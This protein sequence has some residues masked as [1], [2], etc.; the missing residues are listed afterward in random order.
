LSRKYGLTIDNLRS[1]DVVTANGEIVTASEDENADLF[2]GIRGGGGNFGV[3]TSFEFDLH[4]VGTEVLSGLIVHPYADARE[5]LTYYREFSSD[6][7]GD[8]NVWTVLRKAPPMPFL[9]EDVHG[10]E[11]LILAAFWSGDLKQGE[12][13]LRPLREHGNPIADVISPHA[14]T[15]WQTAFDPLL[16]P[17]SRNYWKSHNFTELSDGLLD[18]AVEYL[19]KLPS[20][21]TEIFFGQLGGAVNQVDA[22]ATAYPHRDAEYVMNVHTR[23]ENESDDAA[24]M[25]WAREY[26]DATAEYATGGVYVN[27]VP[28]GEAP[29]AAAYGPNY[30]RLV[31]LKRK[32]DPR[33]LFRLNQNIAP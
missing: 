4:H 25:A 6:L 11:V 32:Y 31:E 22:D 23:W 20:D 8:L 17:G 12:R 9:P 19:G 15:A 18:T 16:T 3:V 7:P 27:F 10:T 21:Q 5:V 33:N 26:F 1:A 30:D 28:E 2:W 13:A 24:C 14:F 29:I